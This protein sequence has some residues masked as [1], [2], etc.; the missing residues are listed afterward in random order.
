MESRY[1]DILTEMGDLEQAQQYLGHSLELA[2]HLDSDLDK[3]LTLSSLARLSVSRGK[4]DEARS[5][6]DQAIEMSRAA[7]QTGSEVQG[8]AMRHVH[9]RTSPERVLSEAL[10]LSGEVATR[11]GDDKKADKAFTEAIDLIERGDGG[12]MA[13]DTYQRYA[14]VLAGRGQ[15]EKA[16]KYF[17]R[18][19]KSVTKRGR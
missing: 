6:V 3:A 19:Y 10:A 7:M 16:S 9:S 4:M 12:E 8:Y 13:S 2:E 1:G 14:Q 18:A 11:S 15:H 17:E 5:Q